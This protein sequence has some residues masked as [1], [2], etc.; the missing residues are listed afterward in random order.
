M[1]HSTRHFIASVK[2]LAEQRRLDLSI[3]HGDRSNTTAKR[4]VSVA[5][6]PRPL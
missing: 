4:G 1:V 3:L 5:P 6:T 2:H